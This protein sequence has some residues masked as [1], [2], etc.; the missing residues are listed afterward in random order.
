[1]NATLHLFESIVLVGGLIVYLIP[2]MEADAREHD[3]A[4]AITLVNVFLG[5]TIVGWFAALRAARNPSGEKRIARVALRVRHAAA[6][7][8]VDKI[9][10]HASNCAPFQ[11]RSKEQGH[12]MPGRCM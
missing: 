11:R 1:M 5:W 3:H 4:L 12:A 2:A 6:H 9:V 8:T 7:A 10:A